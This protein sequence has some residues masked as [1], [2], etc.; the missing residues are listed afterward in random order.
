M[1][2]VKSHILTLDRAPSC[3][4]DQFPTPLRR[5]PGIGAG[6]SC[7]GARDAHPTLTLSS[8]ARSSSKTPAR[9]AARASSRSGSAR[10]T[11]RVGSS[12]GSRSRIQPR[13]L[14]LDEPFSGLNLVTKAALL[15]DIC[16]LRAF[17]QDRLDKPAAARALTTARLGQATAGRSTCREGA[18]RLGAFLRL[19]R[20][21]QGDTQRNF[22]PRSAVIQFK[23]SAI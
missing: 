21:V 14:V 12:T 4:L 17:T 16:R 3:R 2:E 10:R 13:F 15:G 19:S 7:A 11:A 1:Q 6:L 8:M 9:L 18:C 23:P 5:L 20:L 22:R